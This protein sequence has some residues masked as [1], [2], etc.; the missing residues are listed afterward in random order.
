MR[1]REWGGGGRQRRHWCV[2]AELGLLASGPLGSGSLVSRLSVVAVCE[3]VDLALPVG[4]ALPVP[5]LLPL[6]P[7]GWRSLWALRCM[8]RCICC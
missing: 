4:V 6:L 8:C 3:P 1:V 5:L 2:Q 7:V